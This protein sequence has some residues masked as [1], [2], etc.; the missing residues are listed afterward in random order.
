MTASAET[1]P[2]E[3]PAPIASF[4]DLLRVAA[5]PVRIALRFESDTDSDG[6]VLV[7]RGL[8]RLEWDRLVDDH[9]P[10]PEQVKAAEKDGTGRPAYNVD[11]FPGALVSATLEEPNLSPAQAQSWLEA[12]SSAETVLVFSTANEACHARRAKRV[13]P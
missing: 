3:S 10:T 4:E 7:F 8:S 11:T 12:M 1:I 5:E 2:A 6:I 9:P 13:Q